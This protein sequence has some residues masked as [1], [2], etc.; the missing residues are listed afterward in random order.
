M[1]G[2]P[3]ILGELTEDDVDWL[4]ACGERRPVPTGAILIQE[5]V[6]AGCL[7]IVLEGAFDVSAAGLGAKAFDTCSAGDVVGEMSLVDARPPAATVTAAKDSAVFA[8]PM[9]ALT[10]K[11]ELDRGFSA[12]FHR[13][14]AV[15]LSHRL[16]RHESVAR[17]AGDIELAGALSGNVHLARARFDRLVSRLEGERPSVVLTGNDLTIEAVVRVVERRAPV[18]VSPAARSR[19][20]RSRQVVD[21]LASGQQRIYGLHTGLGALKPVTIDPSEGGR[22]QRNIVISHA[23]GVGPGYSSDVVRAMMLARLNGMARGGSG[24]QP[25]VFDLLLGMLNAGIHPLVPTR[26]S[27]GMSDLVPLAHVA[28]PVIGMGDVEFG[29]RRM[30]SLKAFSMAGLRTV[31]LGGKDGLALCSANSASVGHGALVVAQAIDTL[32]SAQV[33]AALSLEAFACPLGLLA[34]PIHEARPYSGQ[35]ISAEKLRRLL[36]GSALWDTPPSVSPVFEPLS[37]RCVAQ[38]HGACHDAL[39]YVRRTVETELN[40]TGDNPVVLIDRQA[41]LPTA[42]FHPAGLSIAF[43]MLAIAFAQVVSMSTHRVLKLMS[44][45]AGLPPQLTPK[46]GVNV[47]MGVLQ[48]TAMA[49]NS[50]VRFLADPASLDFTPV[51]DGVEDHATMATLSVSK[52]D[53]ILDRARYVLAIELLCAAQAVDL[54]GKPALGVGTRATYDAVRAKVPIMIE[55]RPLAQDVDRLQLLIASRELLSAVDAVSSA[56]QP[57]RR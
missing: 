48:K 40:A 13:A 47:G 35:L 34:A 54:R 12:R 53:D 37:F 33:A 56:K 49:L 3:D 28:M 29:G 6:P 57:S 39:S 20:K 2:I 27:V 52:A 7:F 9:E 11:V 42:N 55:D 38:V 19:I 31:E 17:A 8:I 50:E 23:V 45:L 15:F 1:A 24:I 36:E 30:P 4:L 46:P 44:S 22:F 21:R 51:A 10:A 25:A 16:R 43:D 14:L 26:G 32:A 41:V 18:G 5:G